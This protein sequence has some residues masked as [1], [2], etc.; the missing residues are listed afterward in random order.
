LAG[1]VLGA[2]Q[3]DYVA[4]FNTPLMCSYGGGSKVGV[5]VF[6]ILVLAGLPLYFAAGYAYN[7]FALKLEG[8][9]RIPNHAFWSDLP[10]LIKDGCLYFV[11]VLKLLASK[12]GLGESPVAPSPSASSDGYASA[13]G[14]GAPDATPYSYPPAAST[15]GGYG[16][17]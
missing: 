14:P 5:W 17:I 7:T 4:T 3:C 8:S 6:N 12:V 10:A 11:Y 13:E 16:A 9:E 2:T 1:I 15:G